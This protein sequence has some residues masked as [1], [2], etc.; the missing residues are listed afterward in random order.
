G[1]VEAIRQRVG[2]RLE[3]LGDQA[4]LLLTQLEEELALSLGGPELYHPP[5]VHDV[6][7]DIGADPPGGVAGQLDAAARIVLFHRLHQPDVS[8]LNAIEQRQWTSVGL[9]GDL[10]DPPKVGG[11]QAVS[12]LYISRPG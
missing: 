4:I 7:E 9:V 12:G 8:L 10:D 2:V 6:A 11:G 5:V 3:A 1:G